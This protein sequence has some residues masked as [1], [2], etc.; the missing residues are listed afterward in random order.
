MK[1]RLFLSF[2]IFI[3]ITNT[4]LAQVV[5]IQSEDFNLCTVTSPTGWTTNILV[6]NRDWSFNT[7]GFGGGS[8]TGTCAA[9]F[10]DDAAGSGN[11]NRAE[12][13]SPSIDITPYNLPTV[14]FDYNNQVFG[15][16]TGRVSVWDGNAWVVVWEV[17]SN[18]PPG[19][20]GSSTAMIDVSNYKNSNFQVK[21]EFEDFN[22]SWSWGFGIDNHLIEGNVPLQYDARII[23]GAVPSPADEYTQ[24]PLC[25]T[26]D[27][28]IGIGENFGTDTLTNVIVTASL[29]DGVTFLS[30]STMPAVLAAGE[31]DT[32][33]WPGGFTPPNSGVWT[34]EL[35]VTSA[36]TDMDPSNNVISYSIN[37]TDSVYARDDGIST[38]AYGI[39]AGT[40]GSMGNQFTIKY[41]CALNGSILQLGNPNGGGG[42][43]PPVGSNFFI[44]LWS[45]D[46]TTGFPDTVIAE[47]QEV[48]INSNLAGQIHYVQFDNPIILQPGEYILTIEEPAS[49]PNVAIGKASNIWNDNKVW[50][51]FPGNPNGNSGGWSHSA[52]SAPQFQG[53]PIVRM[54]FSTDCIIVDAGKD[55]EICMT[56]STMLGGAP[57][58]LLGVEPYTFAWSPAAGLNSTSIA[59]PMASPVVNTTYTLIVT[60]STGCSITKIVS[61]VVEVLQSP[62][63]TCKPSPHIELDSNGWSAITVADIDAGSYGYD[64][65]YVAPEEVNCESFGTI[66]VTLIVMDS[67]GN[68]STCST[69]MGVDDFIKPM[70]KCRDTTIYLKASGLKWLPGKELDGGSWDNCSIIQWRPS[71]RKYTCADVGVNMVTLN[72]KDQANNKDQCISK[73]TV[74]DPNQPVAT[75]ND[76]T[77]ELDGNGLA[78]IT[79]AQVGGGVSICGIDTTWLDKYDF[80]CVNVGVN[81]VT[82]TV[83]DNSGNMTTCAATV[84][85]EDNEAPTAKCK[86]ITVQLDANGQSS[87]NTVDVNNGSSDNCGIASMSLSPSSFTCANVGTNTAT[88][89]VTDVNG[90]TASCNSTITIED[91]IAPTAQCKNIMVMLDGNGNANISTGD[92]NDG[93]S[94]NCGIQSMS[95]NPSSFTCNDT[96]VNTVTLSV[97]DVNGNTASCQ[98]TVM[99][100]DNEL[101]TITCPA[102]M[103]TNNDAGECGAVVSYTVSVSD[104]CGATLIQTSG[105]ASDSMFPVGTTINTFMATDPS[106]NVSTCSFTITVNDTEPP[107][108]ICHN[109]TRYVKQGKTGRIVRY[110]TPK[111]TENCDPDP[112]V[113]RLTGPPSGAWFP[114]GSTTV[115][116]QSWDA[117][118]NI[119]TCSFDVIVIAGAKPKPKDNRQND[120]VFGNQNK[121]ILNLYPNPT[122]GEVNLNITKEGYQGKI[123][124][125]V[126]NLLGRKVMARTDNM[127]NWYNVQFDLGRYAVGQYMIRIKIG[128]E[129]LTRKLILIR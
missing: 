94:D 107:V 83:M 125:E 19:F 67:C 22:S 47:S 25:Q 46:A 20:F 72:V 48:T 85:V 86:N 35:S 32:F 120:I 21:Y 121:T 64:T 59:N 1:K 74:I 60:D 17:S 16:S 3:I 2:N 27:P 118:G 50:I 30:Q 52:S 51:R 6:G 29:D 38:F 104:N 10:D 119:T 96:G 43:T 113:Q 105:M 93:S 108:L 100:M 58:A 34:T 42:S 41:V 44:R 97:T 91:T 23:N 4:L 77:I 57:T 128:D 95:I 81:T 102:N 37:Y 9:V 110:K 49:S 78:S 106:G 90:N 12:L 14:K 88:L 101:P 99:V 7:L 129:L 80:T 65:I 53:V 89:I 124:I 111:V 98:S 70:A 63:A 71:K 117:A 45:F 36:E 11:A 127:V 55:R 115:T 116:Y 109:V 92:V 33:T 61:V 84:N 87:I 122:N 114:V 5:Q 112:A 40:E 28:V 15:Q 69:L 8:I 76:L 54:V 31:K 24:I 39:G 62:F 126:Y 18:D 103:I 56:D 82:L 66:A 68:I 13:I 26:P 73:V 79:A 75:C 123:S